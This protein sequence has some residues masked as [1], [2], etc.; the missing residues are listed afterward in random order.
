MSVDNVKSRSATAQ[1]SL[2]DLK[3]RF[4]NKAGSLRFSDT[5][6]LHIKRGFSLSG[7]RARMGDKAALRERSNQRDAAAA[8]IK[9]AIDAQ[10]GHEMGER[11]FAEFDKVR[12]S[13]GIRH[14]DLD[15]MGRIAERLKDAAVNDADAKLGGTSHVLRMASDFF[16]KHKCGELRDLDRESQERVLGAMAEAILRPSN[17]ERVLD[18]AEDA[19]MVAASAYQPFGV[20]PKKAMENLRGSDA[21][22]KVSPEETKVLENKLNELLQDPR[23]R[24]VIIEKKLSLEQAVQDAN[25]LLSYGMTEKEAVKSLEGSNVFMAAGELQQ[26]DS[27]SDKLLDDLKGQM[28]PRMLSNHMKAM[29]KDETCRAAIRKYGLKPAEFAALRLYGAPGAY[30]DVQAALRGGSDAAKKFVGP[31][32]DACRSGLAKLPPL[33]PKTKLVYRGTPVF[34]HQLDEVYTDPAFVSTSTK[35]EIGRNF[36]D[37]KFLLKVEL[38]NPSMASGRDVSVLLGK[39]NVKEAEVLFPPGTTF[40]VTGMLT[41]QL[42]DDKGGNAGTLTVVTVKPQ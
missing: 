40:K 18:A 32:A 5:K 17:S 38:D 9:L 28:K 27:S 21:Y 25:F 12:R 7:L 30:T 31:L 3:E 6:E 10:Y 19:F 39:A 20:L 42:K 22:I 14:D 23:A 11:V 13:G 41:E 34:D 37:G 4:R 35:E 16:D 33:D 29:L 36:S 2:T 1:P 15:Q 24:K 26:Q 8:H